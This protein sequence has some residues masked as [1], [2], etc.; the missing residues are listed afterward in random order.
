M[1]IT[2]TNFLNKIDYDK[3]ISILIF[4]YEGNFFKILP[5]ESIDLKEY[6]NNNLL[7]NTKYKIFNNYTEIADLSLEQIKSILQNPDGI[8]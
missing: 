1:S 7:K 6:A 8:V 2:T 3:N 4:E 5:N